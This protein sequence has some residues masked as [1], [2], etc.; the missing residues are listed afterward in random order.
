MREGGKEGSCRASPGGGIGVGGTPFFELHLPLLLRNRVRRPLVT[1]PRAR[2]LSLPHCPASAAVC[3]HSAGGRSLPPWT[4][5]LPSCTRGGEGRGAKTNTAGAERMM[6]DT[7]ERPRPVAARCLP[8]EC[9]AGGRARSHD[10]RPPLRAGRAS[11]GSPPP[12]LFHISF[13]LASA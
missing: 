10:H 1:F 7:G 4:F 5:F 6:V 12:C 13:A 3:I 9:C 2:W 11:L 8:P